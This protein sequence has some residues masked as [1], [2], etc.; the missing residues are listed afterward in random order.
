MK[1]SPKDIKMAIGVASDKRYAGGNMTGAVKAIE[2]IKKGLSSH[3]QV[4]AVLKRQN[5]EKMKTFDE[6]RSE[7][8]E[9]KAA[10]PA[11]QAA[12]AIAKKEKEKSVKERTEADCEGM[13]CK[14]CGD[15]FGMPT[16]GS[17]MYDSKDPNG[18]NWTG[19]VE[20]GA[21]TKKSVETGKVKTGA[22]KGRMAA[23]QKQDD[24]RPTLRKT[25]A[26][27]THMF[28][29]EKDARAKAKEIG[30]KYVKGK[31]KSAG[32]HAAIVEKLDLD[33]AKY[34]YDGKVVKIS[35]KEFAKV[36][37]DYKNTTKGKERMMILDPK[38]QAS[39]SVPVQFEKLD[40]DEAGLPPHLAKLFDKDGNFKDP[41]KQKVFD[42][43]M[44]DG[45]GKEIAQKMGR[46][47]F[48]VDADSAKKKVKVYVDS[49]DEKDAQ[50]A[51]KNH[52]A[53][54]SGALRV[55]PEDFNLEEGIIGNL[56]K[57]TAK[58]AG[59]A[60]VNR[61]TTTGRAKIAQKKID[62]HNTKQDQKDTIAKA[63]AA[64]KSAFGLTQKSR[65]ANAKKKLDKI[66]K[67][68]AAQDTIQ[69]AKNL[70]KK[71]A[72]EGKKMD[73]AAMKRAMDAFKKRGGKVKKVAPGKAAGY[74]GK[75]DPGAD[76]QG[77]MDRGDTKGFNRKKKVKSMGK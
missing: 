13:V 48:R 68:K 63:N 6:L 53:Y 7:L 50:K 34:E 59:G 57:K 19:E 39:I 22:S 14:N 16:E 45:I 46:I 69:K 49:N 10:N 42:R 28:D 11:Q 55:I 23:M 47:K 24:N 17:C 41:K 77:M 56:V 35:K 4:A 52:P 72:T 20:E 36:S 33:E 75:D 61:L 65:A 30:G 40:L 2:K 76:I 26:K 62:K 64:G 21:F 1:Y 37:K 38:T 51:L 60:V 66:A 44:G 32:K 70:N 25:E 71:P 29:N 43:M 9:G 5:E 74:H 3:P 54:V 12:I 67:K 8:A 58:A 31:G 73:S 15:K 27:Q 18:K